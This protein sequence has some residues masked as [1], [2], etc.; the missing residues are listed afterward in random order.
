MAGLNALYPWQQAAW[1]QLV[2]G[3]GRL[4][5]A[6]LLTG[7]PGI[8]KMRFAE[9]L[10][11]WLLCEAPS[12][13]HG[14]CGQCEACLWLA[15]G[16][17]PDFRLLSPLD[18][19][20]GEGK[21]KR[22][23]PVITVDGVRSLTDFVHLTAH[24]GAAKVVV[25]EPAE[26]LNTAAAN[27]LLKTLEEPPSDVHFILVS[28]HWRRL[29]PTIRSRCRVLTMP[30]PAE[31]EAVAWLEGEGISNA[32]LHLAHCGGAPLAAL[33][34]ARA[35]WLPVRSRLL[36]ALANPRSLDVLAMAQELEKSK[37]DVATVL[38]WL[39]R[40]V[41]DIVST[42]LTGKAR[43]FPD[44]ADV[45]AGF[46]ARAERFVAYQDTL[47]DALKLSNHPLN[48]RLVYETVLTDY[49]AVFRKPKTEMR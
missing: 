31:A 27:A 36:D 14:P 9:Y 48:Q 35:D 23:L 29:L 37:V 44:R 17:H 32:S 39:Q 20:E 18:D 15:A 1:Q 2:A 26:T 21:A 5:H 22:K 49:V 40:W 12:H 24:R 16:N 10:A 8:G 25:V 19:E 6:L 43:Y 3:A 30:A 42:G 28:H 34:D 13:Q 7:E 47:R 11:G 45:I 41:Y 33:D 38:G 46:A 4:P